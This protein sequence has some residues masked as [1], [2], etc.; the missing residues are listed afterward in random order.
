MAFKYEGTYLA[1]EPFIQGAQY[2]H[3]RLAPFRDLLLEAVE[4]MDCI[5]LNYMREHLNATSGSDECGTKVYEFLK[6]VDEVLK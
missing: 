4:A 5:A 3:A 6:R 1:G 2:E